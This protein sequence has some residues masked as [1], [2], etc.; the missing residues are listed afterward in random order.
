MT[1]PASNDAAETAT[2]T[3][4]GVRDESGWVNH[5]GSESDARDVAR[6]RGHVLVSRQV[7][8]TVKVSPWKPCE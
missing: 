4:W 1:R 6:R 8:R 5:W 2:W 7:T 3:E